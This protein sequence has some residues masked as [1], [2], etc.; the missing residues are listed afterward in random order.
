MN[1][2]NE[3]NVKPEIRILKIVIVATCIATIIGV[4]VFF[5][6]NFL[7]S[8]KSLATAT[9]SIYSISGDMKS[10]TN[11]TILNQVVDGDTIK[12]NADLDIT[13]TNT[14]LQNKN[15]IILLSGGNLKW[16]GKYKLYLGS[17]AK[18]L[19]NNGNMLTAANTNYGGDASIYFNNT[20]VVS[21]NGSNANYS[22]TQVNNNGGVQLGGLTALPVTLVRFET[23]LNNQ[24]VIVKWT[25]ATEINNSHFE[26]ERSNDNI[27]WKVVGK[28]KGNGNSNSLINYTFTDYLGVFKAP[29]YYRLHQIDFDGKNE[30]GP[31]SVIS[32]IKKENI[33][34]VYPNP[35]NAE[36]KISLNTDSYQLTILD[37]TG[38][39][40][41]SKQVDSDF[42]IIDVKDLP[43]GIYFVKLKN[44]T[45]SENHKIV[46]KH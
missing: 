37:Q 18:V 9:P 35:A 24:E 36:L 39:M 3:P 8:K 12:L 41:I 26:I 1:L 30:Y 29:I 22:F 13:K 45:I 10:S 16:T 11:Q 46:V 40:V 27:N 28:V 20:K 34:K 6:G 21:Y 42:E 31:V 43:N 14:D 33:G 32:S 7:S 5:A 17:G 19:L 25:T 44:E 2:H 15:V 38:K 23:I 4:I